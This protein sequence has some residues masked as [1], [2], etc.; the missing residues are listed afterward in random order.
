MHRH[1]YVIFVTYLLV[2]VKPRSR[3]KSASERRSLSPNKRIYFSDFYMILGK[4]TY[5]NDR[6]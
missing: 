1:S 4:E 6:D 3:M 2:D 5:A